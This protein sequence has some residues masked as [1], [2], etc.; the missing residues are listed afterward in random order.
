MSV[1]VFADPK[2]GDHVC[3]PVG[4]DAEKLDFYAHY[5]AHGVRRGQKVLIFTD[6]VDP[7]QVRNTLVARLPAGARRVLDAQVGV[8]RSRDGVLHHGVFD[9]DLVM[10]AF[11]QAVVQAEL[12]GFDGLRVVTDMAWAAGDVPGVERL[13]DFEAAANQAFVHGRLTAVCMYDHRWFAAEVIE[14]A[15]LAHPITPGQASLRF[16]H[17]PGGVR[18]YGEVDATNLFAFDLLVKPLIAHDDPARVDAAGLRFADLDALR[19]LARAAAGRQA[20][21]TLVAGDHMARILRL[22]GAGRLERLS[23]EETAYLPS[24]PQDPAEDTTEPDEPYDTVFTRSRITTVRHTVARH[25]RRLGLKAAALDD[26]VFAVNETMTNAIRYAGGAGQLRLWS[27]DGF[28]YSEITD[29][30]T[31]IPPDFLDDHQHVL[32]VTACRQGR[33]LVHKLCTVETDTGPFGTTTWIS[34]PLPNQ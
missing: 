26:Y 2:P 11:S 8:L 30:G 17:T 3:L 33:R 14:Q 5:T 9:P 19:L 34:M 12:E 4:S 1:L 7:D 25:A 29:K 13:F 16:A 15:A 22:L 31:G 21:T 28:L 20:P 27:S 24:V 23:I 10:Q 18:F 6:S 32:D